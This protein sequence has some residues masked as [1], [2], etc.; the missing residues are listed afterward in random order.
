VAF[1]DGAFFS[2]CVRLKKSVFGQRVHLET[3]GKVLYCNAI[4]TERFILGIMTDMTAVREEPPGAGGRQGED[5]GGVPGGHQ[6]ADARG[7]GDCQPAGGDDRGDEGQSQPA[8]G[9]RDDG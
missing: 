4:Y 6:Q 8:E 1:L 2:E 7:P 5:A 9:D 3:I